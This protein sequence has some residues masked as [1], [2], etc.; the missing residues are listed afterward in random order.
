LQEYVLATC[1]CIDA[2]LPNIYGGNFSVCA[3]IPLLNCVAQSRVNY[4]E[5]TNTTCDQCKYCFISTNTDNTI[6]SFQP[7][8]GPLECDSSQFTISLSNSRYP[9]R[10][11]QSYL[12]LHTNVN[13]KLL[14]TLL[15]DITKSTVLVN[16]FYDDLATTYIAE[17]PAITPSTLLGAIGGNLVS[18]A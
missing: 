16:V 18:S 1:N 11:Y 3:T 9:S 14:P 5:L 13:S 10:Y 15:A 8:K 6:Y 7:Q 12:T 17:I 2:S 4:F